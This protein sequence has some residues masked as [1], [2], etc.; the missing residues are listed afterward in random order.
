VDVIDRGNGVPLVIIPGL[1]G[2]W[3]YVA[4]AVDALAASC[5]VL[6]CH[7]GGERGSHPLPDGPGALDSEIKHIVDVLDEHQIEQ[8]A[9][10]GISFGGL[11][12]LRFAAAHPDRTAA[13]ILAST[14]GPDFRLRRRHEIYVRAARIFG[15]LFFAE[16]PLRLRAEIKAALPDFRDRLRF[17]RWQLGTLLAAPL[18]VTRMAKRARMI[19]PGHPAEDARRVTVPTLVITGEQT[20]DRVVATD[21]S[22]RYLELIP[23]A[24]HVVIERTGHLGSITKPH[25]FAAVIA[26]FLNAQSVSD[27]RAS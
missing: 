23:N 2:R 5:R 9:I 17:L 20:L 24:R 10:C 21:G 19:A 26:D 7:L 11:I 27:R 22:A 1:Q 6:T 16:T 12:A 13:L 4:P 3:E 14:P 15:L 18:S 8:A 25:A